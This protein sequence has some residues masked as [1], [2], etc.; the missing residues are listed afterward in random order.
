MN[1]TPP[2][3][4]KQD[5]L[6]DTSSDG[7]IKFFYSAAALTQRPVTRI[8][9]VVPVVSEATT[10]ENKP[11]SKNPSVPH[12]HLPDLQSRSIR[13][14]RDK[15]MRQS[16]EGGAHYGCYTENPSR[17]PGEVCNLPAHHHENYWEK[18]IHVAKVLLAR[19]GL[20]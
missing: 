6:A 5:C 12:P 10:I 3:G 15:H 14:K 7:E 16:S 13:L 17:S 1:P 18:V 20:S 8:A 19:M 9:T 4:G 11:A 2:Y